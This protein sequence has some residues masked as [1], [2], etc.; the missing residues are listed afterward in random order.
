MRTDAFARAAGIAAGISQRPVGAKFGPGWAYSPGDHTFQ[1]PLKAASAFSD[2]EKALSAHEAAHLRITRY[3]EFQPF[4]DL[5]RAAFA[6]LLNAIED[7]RVQA[8]AIRAYPGSAP[9]FEALWAME[10]AAP[11][12]R[13]TASLFLQFMLT[14]SIADAFQWRI[15]TDWPLDERVKTALT[16]TADA[17]R[18]YATLELPGPALCRE[19]EAAGGLQACLAR[20]VEPLMRRDSAV[21]PPDQRGEAQVLV[22][23]ARAFTLARRDIL[24]A[25]LALICADLARLGERSASDQDFSRALQ[26]ALLRG[27]N[28]VDL[29]ER[30]LAG[31][32]MPDA[33]GPDEDADD[34]SVPSFLRRTLR[35]RPARPAPTMDAAVLARAAYERFLAE[36]RG[37]EATGGRRRRSLAPLTLASS[38]PTGAAEDEDDDGAVNEDL[39]SR[40]DETVR[41]QLEPLVVRLSQAFRRAPRLRPRAGY[42]S[43]LR[44]DLKAVMRF[45]ADRRGYDRLWTRLRR[46]YDQR[47]AA[48]LI[49]V[50]LSGSMAGDE[51]DAAIRGTSLLAAALHR[52]GPE[53]QF[54]VHGFQDVLVPPFKTFEQPY[55]RNLLIGFE[56][57]EREVGGNRAGGNNQPSHNDDGPCLTEAAQILLRHPCTERLLVVVSDGRPSGRRSNADDLHRA[58]AE[59]RRQPIRLVGLGLGQG[60]THV[61]DFYAPDHVASIPPED[62]ARR[63]GDVVV[64]AL[65][66]G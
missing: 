17:R 9:W 48:V 52:L 20:E 26:S 63:I 28:L 62:F 45:D 51:I 25:A 2:R 65:A 19:I 46:S 30:A 49:L 21:Y 16:D 24:P 5:N 47:R 13:L 37:G 54:A 12:P 50:D 59:V 56:Q 11:P 33:P 7:P 41:T 10:R 60:T 35:A 53:I 31:M 38:P 36:V 18:R 64:G 4:K 6:H 34:L 58:I 57:M 15:P 43:G 3:N 61:A 66:R 44:P 23:A 42:P 32:A 55:S 40:V 39:R 29:V 14:A 1:V 22:S 8:W 27:E